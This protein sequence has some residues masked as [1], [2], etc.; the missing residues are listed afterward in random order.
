MKFDEAIALAEGKLLN[1]EVL[2]EILYKKYVDT[3]IDGGINSIKVLNDR[4]INS[5]GK[6]NKMRSFPHGELKADKNVTMP[7]CGG[8]NE[9]SSGVLAEI[10]KGRTK[11]EVDKLIASFN[12]AMADLKEKISKVNP[13]EED[14]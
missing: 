1:E 7:D 8:F 13:P 14:K 4:I 2:N 12:A 11:E 5:E 10:R 6:P 3:L 9:F